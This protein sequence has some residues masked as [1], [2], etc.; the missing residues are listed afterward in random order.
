M[1]FYRVLYGMEQP[2][3]QPVNQKRAAGLL[4][5]QLQLYLAY[6]LL[7]RMCLL[8]GE[9]LQ[10]RGKFHIVFCEPLLAMEVGL[11]ELSDR[12]AD[13]LLPGVPGMDNIPLQDAADIIAGE[14]DENYAGVIG[15]AIGVEGIPVQEAGVSFLVLVRHILDPVGAVTLQD[16]DKFKMVVAVL[17]AKISTRHIANPSRINRKI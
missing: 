13:Q 1:V 4:L 11:K 16:I 14:V 6:N 12:A 15:R 9:G 10:G 3:N 17:H 7:Q 5:N 2:G 8:L